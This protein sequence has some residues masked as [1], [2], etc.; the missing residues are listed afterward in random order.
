MGGTKK[1][2]PKTRPPESSVN[3]RLVR[4]IAD[5][6]VHLRGTDLSR[7]ARPPFLIEGVKGFHEKSMDKFVAKALQDKK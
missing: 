7:G 4:N 2:Q 3:F 1:I 6:C 5:I